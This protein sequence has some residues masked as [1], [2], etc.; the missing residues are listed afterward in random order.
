[1]RTSDATKQQ[2]NVIAHIAPD[3]FFILHQ[4]TFF[5]YNTSNQISDIRMPANLTVNDEKK[6]VSRALSGDGEAFGVIY[7]S[8]KDALY[9]HV[10]FPRIKDFK[11]AEE[12]LQDTFLTALNKLASFEWQDRS[13]FFWLRMIAINKTRE[14]LSESAR[15]ETVDSVVLDFHPDSTFQPEDMVVFEDYSAVLRNRINVIL[16]EMNERYRQAVDLRLLQKKSREDCAAE[17]G[18]SIETFDVLFFRAC[19]SFKKNFIDKYGSY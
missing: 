12:I 1:M 16:A 5:R 18:L 6:L 15:H 10:I 19:K 8:Y 9:R 17:L 4:F 2:S 14:K 7:D 11:T 13:I 3:L